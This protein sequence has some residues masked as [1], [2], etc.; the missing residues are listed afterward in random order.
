LKDPCDIAIEAAL[1]AGAILKNEF[2]S[3]LSIEYKGDINI[4]TN[5]DRK[6][7]A[8]IASIIWGNF[9]THRILA[10]EG[11][12]G[13]SDPDWLWI[14]DPLDG[15]TNYS[16]GYP[17]FAVSIAAYQKGAAEVGVVYAPMAG[18]LFVARCGAG[19]ELNGKPIHVSKTNSLM[20]SLVSTGFPYDLHTGA[21]NLDH[22]ANFIMQAQAVRR[23]GSA[24]L[25]LCA[26]AAGRFDGFWE[27]KLSPWD[28][29]AGALIV[30]EAGGVVTNFVNEPFV[31]DSGE[32][33]AS[34]GVIHTEMTS[35]LAKGRRQG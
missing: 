5:L 33:L 10:E 22:W 24:A 20:R 12:A 17:I 23:D 2:G 34:N 16:H 6:S 21:N 18:E 35:I 1:H 7:E 11:T 29:A 8:E 31:L 14:V 9:P 32:I 4:V 27:F 15:T 28:M 30:R 26:V 3:S 25:N 19:A 13:G